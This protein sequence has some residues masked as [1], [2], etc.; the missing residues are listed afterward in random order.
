MLRHK[1]I[2]GMN[3]REQKAGIYRNQKKKASIV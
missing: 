2:T 3:Y 1:E